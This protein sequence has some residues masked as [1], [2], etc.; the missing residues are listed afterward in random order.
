MEAREDQK[1]FW[2]VVLVLLLLTRIP[3]VATYLSIDNV[4]VAFSLERFDPRVHQPQPPGYSFFVGFAHI[5]NLPFR[6]P[7]RTFT[8][9][10]VLV[11]G[12]SLIMAFQLGKRMFSRWTGIAGAFLLVVNP[13]FWHSGLDGPLRPNLALFSLLTAYCCWRCWNGE[14]QFAIWGALALGVG[15]GFRPDLIAFLLPLWLISTWL[16]TK[17]FRT[18]VAAGAVLASVVLVWTGAMV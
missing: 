16:G 10:S 13:V 15:S 2:I 9:I 4:N 18:I 17:S 8:F 7:G 1:V 12:L 6:D 11:S 5:V 3:A 14:K